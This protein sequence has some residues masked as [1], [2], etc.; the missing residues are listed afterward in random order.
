M[1][2][3]LVGLGAVSKLNILVKIN[4]IYNQTGSFLA[5]GV[6]WL[7]LGRALSV[8]KISPD[9]RKVTA[10]ASR[11]SSKIKREFGDVKRFVLL[12]DPSIM[13][14][15]ARTTKRQ[16]SFQNGSTTETN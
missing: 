6:Y 11:N 4:L 5:S 3:K 13:T 9:F 14:P 16:N 10:M 7:S 8:P 12:G 15:S 1:R 2:C